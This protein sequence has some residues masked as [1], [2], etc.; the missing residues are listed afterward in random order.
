MVMRFRLHR[1]FGSVM[2]CRR[3]AR[4]LDSR[5]KPLKRQRGK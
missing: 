4:R 3:T 2:V 1:Y 5:S